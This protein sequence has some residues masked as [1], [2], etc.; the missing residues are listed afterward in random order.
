MSYVFICIV[1]EAVH[2]KSKRKFG[3]LR[4]LK[5]CEI[6]FEKGG[7]IAAAFQL[8][9]V[10]SASAAP[11]VSGNIYREFKQMEPLRVR[12]PSEFEM[13]FLRVFRS[14]FLMRMGL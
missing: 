4:N 9:L 10:A 1:M 11:F 8:S 6:I 3:F 13:L 12:L 7:V 5:G 2:H 14:L